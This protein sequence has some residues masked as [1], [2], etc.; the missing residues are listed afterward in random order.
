MQTHEPEL[1]TGDLSLLTLGSE[2][3]R[4]FTENPTA[5]RLWRL[6]RRT[7]IVL[8]IGN[9]IA[10]ILNSLPI[11][12][13]NEGAGAILI[14]IASG[15][16]GLVAIA[17][18]IIMILAPF[19]YPRW[20]FDNAWRKDE[21]MRLSDQTVRE[22]LV[23]IL[24]PL[25][26]GYLMI[27]IPGA[28]FAPFSLYA[29]SQAISEQ[30]GGGM[31]EGIASGFGAVLSTWTITVVGVV[32]YAYFCGVIVT[33]A[34]IV[35]TRP[36]VKPMF[37][38][39]YIIGPT[40]RILVTFFLLSILRAMP[41]VY[42]FGTLM[43]RM[44]ATMT[45][46]AATAR[47]GGPPPPPPLAGVGGM[48]ESFWVFAYLFM[49]AV[50]FLSVYVLHRAGKWYWRRDIPIAREFLFTDAPDAPTAAAPPPRDMR[51]PPAPPM[52]QP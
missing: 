4:S 16:G 46:A 15:I 31:I 40:I 28:I 1:Y 24:S 17:A 27:N 32:G 45:A 12:I 52:L 38:R 26:V 47:A 19:M 48:E 9:S 20:A 25:L 22:R 29:A 33:R 36:E 18:L 34:L 3:F 39:G 49:I 14:P 13:P 21:A 11:F 43:T 10:V 51:L 42:W 37:Q 7:V 8:M 6:M 2:V 35:E 50:D 5:I 41:F 23:G 30:F 44:F